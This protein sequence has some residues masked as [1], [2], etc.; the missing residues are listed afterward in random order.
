MQESGGTNPLYKTVAPYSLSAQGSQAEQTPGRS[1]LSTFL[2]NAT[3]ARLRRLAGRMTPKSP[4]LSGS[5]RR[6]RRSGTSKH[7]RSGSSSSS[8]RHRRQ[9]TFPGAY[10]QRNS[11][12]LDHQRPPADPVYTFMIK[13]IAA[14]GFKFMTTTEIAFCAMRMYSHFR[15]TEGNYK[16]LTVMQNAENVPPVYEIIW[17]CDGV[18]DQNPQG[19]SRFFSSTSGTDAEQQKSLLACLLALS[20]DGSSSSRKTLHRALTPTRPSKVPSPEDIFWDEF[21]DNTDALSGDDEMVA[22]ARVVLL[23]AESANQP[24]QDETSSS[25]STTQA[26]SASGDQEEGAKSTGIDHG[27]IMQAL[28]GAHLREIGIAIKEARPGWQEAHVQLVSVLLVIAYL[29]E[30]AKNTLP[31]G[32]RPDPLS[33][34]EWVNLLTPE[35]LDAFLVEKMEAR[36]ALVELDLEPSGLVIKHDDDGE[37]ERVEPASSEKK[38]G[39]SWIGSRGHGHAQILPKSSSRTPSSRGSKRDKSHRRNRSM[40]SSSSTSS[41]PSPV[42]ITTVLNRK[43][44]R[45]KKRAAGRR[46]DAASHTTSSA[47]ASV[48][49][50][51][52]AGAQGSAGER[53]HLRTIAQQKPAGTPVTGK[54]S[55]TAAGDKSVPVSQLT[56]DTEDFAVRVPAEGSSVRS[57]LSRGMSPAASQ[58]SSVVT[59]VYAPS[60][61]DDQAQ[62]PRAGASWTV[63]GSDGRRSPDMSQKFASPTNQSS[64]SAMSQV[65]I[66]ASRFNTSP[67]HARQPAPAGAQSVGGADAMTAAGSTAGSSVVPLGAAAVGLSQDLT[68]MSVGGRGG[69]AGGGRP[70]SPSAF[71]EAGPS[72]AEFSDAASRFE[73]NPASSSRS[74]GAS[75]LRARGGPRG[76]PALAI[77]PPTPNSAAGSRFDT[78]SPASAATFTSRVGVGSPTAAGAGGGRRGRGFGGAPLTGTSMASSMRSDGGSSFFKNSA[79]G[80]SQRSVDSRGMGGAESASAASWDEDDLQNMGTRWLAD[81]AYN[82]QF[83][84]QK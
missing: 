71:S 61:V 29:E 56:I 69:G 19:E 8:R 16:R 26:R 37:V 25:S 40:E 66:A 74:F 27:D 23:I 79:G 5:S 28:S 58:A 76:T 57:G 62:P 47:T 11:S 84:E 1:R 82:Q 50:A 44:S 45:D 35:A 43:T 9:G 41:K 53:G 70:R 49:S 51:A 55:P 42:V 46:G 65:S 3:P 6:S 60:S 64:S 83:D 18:S 68:G 81:R 72:E 48:D 67:T 52:Q 54:A 14:K 30:G 24:G 21:K 34:L 20:W 32:K 22:V 75:A 36:R 4:A 78:S 7:S 2:G 77:E 13:T 17:R 38:N 73:M 39:G 12:E 63:E 15:R 33:S 31:G 59:R 10:S 80:E